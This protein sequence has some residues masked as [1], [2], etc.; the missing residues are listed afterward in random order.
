MNHEF[1]DQP[2]V[3]KYIMEQLITMVQMYH[4]N[5]M[6]QMYH[7]K[8]VV[9][10]TMVLPPGNYPGEMYHRFWGGTSRYN[11]ELWYDHTTPKTMVNLKRVLPL[12]PYHGWWYYHG[13]MYHGEM[14]H[15]FWGGTFDTWYVMVQLITLVQMYH[16]KNHGTI[17]LGNTCM[18]VPW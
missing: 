13:R 6:V 7:P 10:S 12:W 3:P 16:P 4:G 11:S 18:V 17:H 2:F 15:G 14:Y 9:H 5:T 8:N 1:W